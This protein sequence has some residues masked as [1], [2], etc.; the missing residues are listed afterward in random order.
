MQGNISKWQEMTL[1]NTQ[2]IAKIS[3]IV[4]NNEERFEKLLERLEKQE[5]DKS[6]ARIEELERKMKTLGPVLTICYYPKISLVT[7]ILILSLYVSDIRHPVLK[8]LGF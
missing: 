6:Q 3:V 1:E 2:A 4:Q 7:I 5:I 8:F